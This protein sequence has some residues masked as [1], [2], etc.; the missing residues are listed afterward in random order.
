MRGARRMD[1]RAVA[2]VLDCDV[3]ERGAFRDGDPD[4]RGDIRIAV[5]D[6]SLDHR[7][8]RTGV[9]AEDDQRKDGVRPRF[10]VCPHQLNRRGEPHARRHV[11]EG[12]AV[13]ERRSE[14]GEP[15]AWACANS[16]TF[17][18]RGPLRSTRLRKRETATR[19]SAFGPAG[20]WRQA[21]RGERGRPRFPLRAPADRLRVLLRGRSDGSRGDGHP[22]GGPAE[23]RERPRRRARP[24]ARRSKRSK[25]ARRC[26]RRPRPPRVL[27]R[28]RARLRGSRA[29]ERRERLRRRVFRIAHAKRRRT[30]RMDVTLSIGRLLA[31]NAPLRLARPVDALRGLEYGGSTIAEGRP[32]GP[33]SRTGVAVVGFRSPELSVL[34]DRRSRSLKRRPALDRRRAEHRRRSCRRN[35]R[36]GQVDR[37]ARAR[38]ALP[39]STSYRAIRA[40]VGRKRA[41]RARVPTPFVELPI[42][43]T[44][45]RVIGTLDVRAL[46]ARER[47]FEPGSAGAR[48]SRRSLRR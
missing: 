41:N 43:A 4:Q 18:R 23:A 27:R 17:G 16:C 35:T 6:V 5:A 36:H 40:I 10:R 39:R 26:R 12:T 15:V 37:R 3:V 30:G 29:S 2:D 48:E 34:R 31:T 9:D 32:R 28:G 46:L 38:G 14:G 44:E 19:R 1:A 22:P 24:P 25:A 21:S 42:G 33:E 11:D 13:R 45:E 47:R 20:P 8:F 7:R